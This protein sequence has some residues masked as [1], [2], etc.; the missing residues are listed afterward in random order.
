LGIA[1]TKYHFLKIASYHLDVQFMQNQAIKKANI[2]I[3]NENEI[4]KLNMQS[5]LHIN[6]YAFH[7]EAGYLESFLDRLYNSNDIANYKEQR[8]ANMAKLKSDL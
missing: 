4:Y 2:A 5:L 6:R 8:T 1:L 7:S 3:V